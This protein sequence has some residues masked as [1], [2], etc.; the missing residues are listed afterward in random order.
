[1]IKFFRKTR[2]NLLSEG[3]MGKYFKYALGEI[4]LV[5]IGILIA[6]SI[7]N[8]NAKITVNEKTNIYLEALNT[9]IESNISALER[10]IDIAHIDIKLHS[11]T[12][13]SLHPENF[14]GFNDSI[15][16]VEIETS[17]IYK[18]TILK[19]TLTDLINSGYLK[20]MTDITLKNRILAID[21]DI[22]GIYERFNHARA[23]WEEYQLP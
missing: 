6:L 14:I 10:H 3:K 22:D 4:I 5:V 20:N 8:W 9:E 23:V 16:E 18:P 2:Q 21:A 1:M 19:T 17:P 7:N 13:R 11:E 12:L 15:F